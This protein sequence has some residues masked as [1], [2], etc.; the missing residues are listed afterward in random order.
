VALLDEVGAGPI[1]LDTAP[2]IYLIEEHETF[3]PVVEPVFAAIDGGRIAAVTS[4][5]TLLEVLVV[6]L[7]AADMALPRRYE[8]LLGNSRGLELVEVS[9][10][11]LR[12]AAALRAATGMRTPDAI[13][14]ATALQRGCTSFV[15]NDRDL[16]ALPGLRILQLSD[17]LPRRTT[18]HAPRVS[19]R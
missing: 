3:L 11:A 2:F 6:P 8:A 9:R 5:L 17:F 4:A 15:T 13:Q 18:R 19:E 12:D 10:A 16:S 1:A 7:R 14:I